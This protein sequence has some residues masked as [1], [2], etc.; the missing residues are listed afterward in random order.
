M[1]CVL[2][3]STTNSQY[4]AE[5]IKEEEIKLLSSIFDDTMKSN[6][7]L[8][9]NCD[10]TP[11]IFHF[12][13]KL[14]EFFYTNS[15]EINN[16]NAD[17]IKEINYSNFSLNFKSKL[18]F[19]NS[20]RILKEFIY[21]I[22]FLTKFRNENFNYHIKYDNICINYKSINYEDLENLLTN[23][24]NNYGKNLYTKSLPRKINRFFY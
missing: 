7:D 12:L 11:K 15:L 13:K 24:N 20:Y 16:K 3:G 21:L 1:G 17:N 4:S 22:N 23:G 10:I 5:I 14:F 18:A 8:K 2:N 6:Y 19:D 9:F